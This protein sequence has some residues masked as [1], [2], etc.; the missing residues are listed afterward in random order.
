MTGGRSLDANA[1]GQ[2]T[3]IDALFVINRLNRAGDAEGEAVAAAHAASIDSW[4]AQLGERPDD[5]EEFTPLWI[6]DLLMA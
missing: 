4:A 5:E 2:I 3:P 1:D 6:E